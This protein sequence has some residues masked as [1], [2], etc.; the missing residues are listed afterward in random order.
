MMRV[1]LQGIGLYAPGLPSW[2]EAVP[3]LRG[4]QA[5]HPEPPPPVALPLPSA[6]RRRTSASARAAWAAA[7]QALADAKAD[8]RAVSTVFASSGGDGAILH[9]LCLALA[10]PDRAVSPTQFHNSVHNAPAGYYGI[11]TGSHSP[12]NS[13]C[14]HRAPFAAGLLEAAVQVGT[15]QRRQGVWPFAKIHGPRRNHH[16]RTGA[17]SDHR[18]ALSASIT[19]AISPL[20]APRAILT[21]T[22]SISSSTALG[23]VPRRRRGRFATG[24]A[25]GEGCC[26]ITAGTKRGARADETGNGIPRASISLRNS[27]RQVNSCEGQMPCRRATAL[28]VSCPE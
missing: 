13:L 27:R 2:Q 26:S 12:S 3:V 18:V 11:A 5:W 22:P 8:A 10:A 9:Q 17:G 16:S 23:G 21:A 20:S 19:A 25:S 7:A 24:V 14:C 15:D 4:D 6:E 1:G 28:M